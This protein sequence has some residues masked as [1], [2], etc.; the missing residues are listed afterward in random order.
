[1][2][3]RSR[4]PNFT[5]PIR[6]PLYARLARYRAA[7]DHARTALRYGKTR[8]ATEALDDAVRDPQEP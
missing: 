7:I 8:E 2:R 6:L 5:K 1:M 3:P 4:K